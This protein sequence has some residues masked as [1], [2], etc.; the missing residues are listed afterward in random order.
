MIKSFRD[1]R[2]VASFLGGY[3]K[4]IPADLAERAQRKLLIPDKAIALDELR[5]PPGNRLEVPKRSRAGQ[6]AI[7]VNDQGRICF[8]W[9]AAG[10]EDVG[11]TDYH[12]ARTPC[13][14]SHEPTRRAHEASRPQRECPRPGPAGPATRIGAIIR[15]QRPRAVT[16]D[17]AMRLGRYFGSSAEFWLSLQVH[18]DLALARR[19]NRK[20]VERDAQRR[21]AA[22]NC[23]VFR[24]AS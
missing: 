22:W 21:Q 14:E 2:T 24:R 23:T 15:Q 8:R 16:A 12:R 7:R 1:K 6:H 19:R 3:V 4:G 5:S 13:S 11:F 17:T 9:T 18:Y 20:T 10:V